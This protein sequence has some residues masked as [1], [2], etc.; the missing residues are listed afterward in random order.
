M[1]TLKLEN[2]NE[3]VVQIRLENELTGN[4]LKD[5]VYRKESPTKALAHSVEV[6]HDIGV[7][8]IY[9]A[10]MGILS[11]LI[12]NVDSEVKDLYLETYEVYIET[13]RTL[14]NIYNS[15]D[16]SLRL[17]FVLLNRSQYLSY[18]GNNAPDA[19]AEV[20]LYFIV[21]PCDSNRNPIDKY[22][23]V[24]NLG[25]TFDINQDF[26]DSSELKHRVDAYKQNTMFMLISGYCKPEVPT[27]GI[28]YKWEDIKKIIDETNSIG[29]SYVKVEF[30]LGEVIPYHAM[31]NF[32]RKNPAY[33]L[34]EAKY[35]KAYE[36]Q[37]KRLTVLGK[38]IPEEILGKEG[39]F[40][41]G[42]LYP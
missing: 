30:A 28:Y 26:I 21:T 39:Y 14:Y 20:F 7:M 5:L 10:N 2:E 18:T 15:N 33:G 36:G 32:F 4:K 38:Y 34:D 17:D 42:S 6:H 27:E 19:C 24:F 16:G 22:Y 25:H 37:E 8:F 1:E 40:D 35:Q 9:Q 41:M 23:K 11:K 12:D 3:K 13:I 31:S 29:K